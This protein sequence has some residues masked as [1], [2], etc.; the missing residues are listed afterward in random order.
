MMFDS[1]RATSSNFAPV[2]HVDVG[3]A[4]RCDLCE[5]SETDKDFTPD[6]YFVCDGKR[7]GKPCEKNVCNLC[8][9]ANGLDTTSNWFHCAAGDC[10]A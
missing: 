4:N 9:A 8:C 6:L 10:E 2:P 1:T 3:E 7:E 5:R